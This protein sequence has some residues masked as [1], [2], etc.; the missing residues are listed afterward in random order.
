MYKQSPVNYSDTMIQ[1]NK[2]N[3]QW[4]QASIVLQWQVISWIRYRAVHTA[5]AAC[6]T[7]GALCCVCV[8]KCHTII[9][10]IDCIHSFQLVS[11]RLWHWTNK[12]WSSGLS[13]IRLELRC[14][15]LWSQWL[16]ATVCPPTKFVIKCNLREEQCCF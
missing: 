1:K 13:R 5:Q 2:S 12:I 10:C 14:F 3:K 9:L 11:V 6:P 4:I 8:K 7:G 15:L 16:Q